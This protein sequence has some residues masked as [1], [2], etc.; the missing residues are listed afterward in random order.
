M[1]FAERMIAFLENTGDK[2]AM[3]FNEPPQKP[4]GC[5]RI[6][7]RPKP[8]CEHPAWGKVYVDHGYFLACEKCEAVYQNGKLF[9]HDGGKNNE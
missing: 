3:M 9:P 4:C 5:G 1:T 6:K 2:I 7:P 8:P